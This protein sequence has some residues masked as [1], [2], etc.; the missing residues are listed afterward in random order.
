MTHDYLILL[1]LA[2]CYIPAIVFETTRPRLSSP[3]F[4]CVS[5]LTSKINSQSPMFVYNLKIFATDLKYFRNA[6]YLY[7]D[8]NSISL[9]VSLYVY[10]RKFN[11]GPGK[12]FGVLVLFLIW[13]NSIRWM[14]SNYK[15]KAMDFKVYDIEPLDIYI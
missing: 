15:M 7:N 5:L 11:F 9:K 4:D 2:N 14:N 3:A 8:H 13:I 6:P 12:N 10:S 1:I